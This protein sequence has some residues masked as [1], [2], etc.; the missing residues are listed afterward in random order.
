M[1]AR[2]SGAL[3]VVALCACGPKPGPGG[4]AG[5]ASAED[6]AAIKSVVFDAQRAGFIRH[7]V[8][9]Y[10]AQWTDDA[11]QVSARAEQPGPYDFRMTRAQIEAT[12]RLR[13][14]GSSIINAIEFRDP[15]IEVDGDGAVM[16]VVSQVGMMDSSETVGEIYKLRR[17][18][19][20]WRVHENRFWTISNMQHGEVVQW[21]PERYAA[22]DERVERER[23]DG[24]TYELGIALMEAQRYPEAYAAFKQVTEAQ[25]VEAYDWVMRAQLAM[26]VGEVEDALAS[27]AAALALDA[28]MPVPA[29]A[30]KTRS[31]RM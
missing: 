9:A 15:K 13:F 23:A 20:G 21:T 22:L 17:T 28:S 19:E 4:P 25:D 6:V 3:A 5:P 12:K 24:D 31:G 8:D 30:H 16:H 1:I 27:Y 7:D 18:P 10:M 29:Y 14:D 26:L 11:T 2:L